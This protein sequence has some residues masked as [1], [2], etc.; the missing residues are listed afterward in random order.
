MMNLDNEISY[1]VRDSFLDSDYNPV[2]VAPGGFYHRFLAQKHG[3]VKAISDA[4]G[5]KIGSIHQIEPPR[6]V[7]LTL[8]RDLAWHLD[9]IE[10]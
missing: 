3:S 1:I 10:F 8:A 9:W 6:S 4:Y 2:N 5:M 7:P